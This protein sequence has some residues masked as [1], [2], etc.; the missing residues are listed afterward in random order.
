MGTRK[1]SV[2]LVTTTP[3]L[4][5]D[6]GGRI[7]AWGTTEPLAPD[8]DYHL[9][10]MANTEEEADFVANRDEQLREYRRVFR[11][12]HIVKRPPIPAQLNR[13]A[14]L[15]HL[16]FH[17]RNGLPLMDVSYYSEEAVTIAR[18]VVR[19]HNIDLLEV[20]HLQMSF[21]KKFVQDIPAVL[22]SHNIEGDLHPF[23]PT[24]RWMPPAMVV[25][26]AFGKLSRRNTRDIE[27][28]NKFRFD[29]K[30]FISE[31]DME[32][33]GTE[34]PKHLLPVPMRPEPGHRGFSADRFSI[35]WLGGF[36]WPPNTEGMVW[37]MNEVWPRFRQLAG[38]VPTE[39]HI[40]G[41]HP[42]DE[43]QRFDGTDQ[44]AVH[45]Y[46]SDV[47]MW[48]D[49]AD[50]LIAPLLSGS[51][52][53]VKIVEALAAGLPVVS[54]PKGREGL[55]VEDG[56]ELLVAEDAE[57]FATELARLARSVDVRRRL[58]D[59]AKAYVGRH[60][61]PEVAA[62]VKADVFRSVLDGRS[63]APS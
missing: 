23:W 1:R 60:H 5:L 10:A 49:G 50:A 42:P 11:S 7:Y 2:L 39:L 43:I 36:D 57:G 17:A 34:C 19:S 31:R 6:S 33:V 13:R 61:A 22:V 24:H 14:V 15:R 4:P 63:Q 48:K 12:V 27:L 28:G 55:P 21:V 47:A 3:L 46:V 29:A 8:W 20:D 54:T 40:V 44:I 35:L 38:D 45:G 16:S 53:R 41:R 18:D 56:A 52:V 25:W 26:L 30:L 32:R 51:G 9:L 58:S 59:A 62:A 37:F